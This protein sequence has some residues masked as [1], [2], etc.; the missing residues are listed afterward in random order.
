M[1]AHPTFATRMSGLGCKK[2][3]RRIKHFN[4][5]LETFAELG[6]MDDLN[7]AGPSLSGV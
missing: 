1:Y 2:K 5:I 3:V 7:A 6:A 4:V